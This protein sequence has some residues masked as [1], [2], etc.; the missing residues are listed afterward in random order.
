MTIV[1]LVVG[2]VKFFWYPEQGPLINNK[3]HLDA[4]TIS[5]MLQLVAKIHELLIVASLS[6]IMLAMSRR[7][8]ITDGLRLGFLT[9]SYR[10]G[11][12]GYLKTAAF[13]RQGLATL[14]PWEVLLS[15]FLVFATIM[16]TIV[17]PASAVLLIPTLDWYEY[18]KGTAFG[19]L[20]TPLLYWWQRD[21]LWIS[22]LWSTEQMEI[23]FCNTIAGIYTPECP[24]GGFTEMFTWVQ[25]H[26]AT[27]LRN[28]L[29]FSATSSDLRRHVVFAQANFSNDSAYATLSTTAP[30]F[31]LDSI[32]LFQSY[33]NENGNEKVGAVSSE[34]RYN[35]TI[36]LRKN[37]SA[38]PELYQPFV[39]SKC[40][41]YNKDQIRNVSYPEPSKHFRCFNDKRGLDQKEKTPLFNSPDNE[42]E[43]YVLA[44]SVTGFWTRKDNDSVIFLSGAMQNASS[45]KD[46]R[47]Y[48]ACS[49]TANWVPTT[50]STDLG[51]SDLLQTS[52][53][54]EERMR[55]QCFSTSNHGARP[56]RFYESWFEHAIPSWSFGNRNTTALERIVQNF[57]DFQKLRNG[58]YEAWV[59]FGEYRKKP[60]GVLLARVF[61]GYLTD[62]LAR[63]AS[64]GRPRMLLSK[65]SGELSFIDLNDQYGVAGGKHRFIYKNK[66]SIIDEWRGK[67]QPWPNYSFEMVLGEVSNSLAFP[68]QA[69]RYGYGTGQERKTLWFAQAMMLIYLGAVTIYASIVL[70]A[71][72]LD[73]RDS[74]RGLERSGRVQSVIP[75]S[76]MQDLFVLGL[77]TKL[78]SAEDG[79]LADIGTGVD[80]IGVWQKFII[81][82]AD[83]D[84]VQFI[85]KGP[86]DNLDNLDLTGAEQYR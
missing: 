85:F 81:A 65:S 50:F 20:E 68:L 17:G 70:A 6:S 71:H 40:E 46:T 43:K 4:E 7:R 59:E 77:R 53:S 60:L 16:S 26:P 64:G 80:S 3:Y 69:R 23:N 45:T 79:D 24:A 75:W 39:Q 78:P 74:E 38:P 57:V 73:Y 42:M 48:Y 58:S 56:V 54:D 34:P 47:I 44:S 82:K 28:N 5:N 49:L 62:V 29:T 86:F 15:G 19:H 41:V 55:D 9:G 18:D 14:A 67:T 72:A 35:L 61:G 63:E 11:D 2:R 32:G 84:K 31:L 30:Q 22:E 83:G 10:V 76:D 21:D 52:W 66:T 51:A 25:N 33:I 36:G 13:W 27:Q 37:S 1:V 12:L 8:L